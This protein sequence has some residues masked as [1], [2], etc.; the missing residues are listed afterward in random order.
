MSRRGRRPPHRGGD[1]RW[2]A[3]ASCRADPDSFYAPDRP[4]VRGERLERERRAKALCAG[5]PV[6]QECRDLADRLEVGPRKEWF[7]IWGG[8]NE[9]ERARRR[10]EARWRGLSRSQTG[11]GP[12]SR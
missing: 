11:D 1:G 10:W 8:E 5:C 6:V 3:S 4:E 2:L 7:G 9:R 12:G